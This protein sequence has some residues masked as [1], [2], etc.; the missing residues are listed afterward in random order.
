MTVP[1]WYLPLSDA[2]A[3]A[4]AQGAQP[5]DQR[6]ARCEVAALLFLQHLPVLHRS[7]PTAL[8]LERQFAGLLRQHTAQ[9]EGALAEHFE[10]G[11]FS[12]GLLLSS[13]Y[14]IALMDQ[15]AV[16]RQAY[17][18]ADGQWDYDYA[19][20][21]AE[22][23]TPLRHTYHTA[24]G[25]ALAVSDHQLRLL[26]TLQ[27][28]PDESVE[29]QAHAGTG[30]THLLS[31]ILEHLGQARC[32]FLADTE[33]KLAPIRERFPEAHTATFLALAAGSVERALGWAF[34]PHRSRPDYSMTTQDVAQLLALPEVH[35]YTPTQVAAICRGAVVKYCASR[36]DV[37]D[38]AHI[39]KAYGW[40]GE[41]ERRVLV[42]HARRLWDALFQP[43]QAGISLPIR[44]AHWIKRMALSAE[45]IDARYS[46]VLIDE[47]HDLT[48]PLLQILDRSP[49]AV[50]T[51]GDRY[52]NLNGVALRHDANIRH[53][54][55][56]LSLRAGVALQDLVN[57]LIEAYPGSLDAPFEGNRTRLTQLHPY[58]ALGIPEQPTLILVKDHWGMWDWVQRLASAGVR[59]QVVASG[60]DELLSL[61]PDAAR[62]FRSDVRSHRAD[63]ARYRSWDQLHVAKAA[64]PSFLR[65]TQW[66]ASH[67]DH[68]HLKP[69]YSLLA[70]RDLP[71]ASGY[72]VALVRDVR[73]FEFSSLAL[74]EDLYGHAAAG[75][76]RELGQQLALLYTAMT[77]VR[78]QLYLPA[79]HAELLQAMLARR[80]GAKRG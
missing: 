54:D 11:A 19:A 7:R 27:A 39:P 65:V 64:C 14:G 42:Q 13:A 8:V 71:A 15:A 63:L 6:L 23:E 47:G 36:D 50:I 12:H 74:T 5:A 61:V 1:A 34:A 43:P 78:D 57:P 17:L 79:N 77:R 68:S 55:M 22:R 69:W 76:D 18:Q 80:R 70:P 53:R 9:L 46:H 60:P 52:Q 21:F 10:R 51:L 72:R 16:D 28:N 38:L 35:P 73:N 41:A 59:C 30:K 25:R 29:A 66:L 3:T 58:P 37:L 48:A 45:V 33:A 75:T 4:L 44:A 40:L 20:Q 62:L 67:H 24:S 31:A 56:H 49:Q 2:L 26:Q 32:L